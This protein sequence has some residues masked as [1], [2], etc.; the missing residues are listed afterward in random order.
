[1]SVEVVIQ[2]ADHLN[3]PHFG[4]IAQSVGSVFA[5]AL[6]Y[7]YPLRVVGPVFLISP[8]VSTQA[9]NTF[10][11]ARRLPA[12]LVTRTLSI[13]MDVMWM[14][15]KTTAAKDTDAFHATPTPS[16]SSPSGKTSSPARKGSFA[17]DSSTPTTTTNNSH[18][19]TIH[20][21]TALEE[22]E[23]L[24]SLE[25]QR[26][27]S[28]DFPPHRPLRH[29]VRPKH[30]SLYLAMNRQRM[31]EPCSQGQLGDVL[32][33]LEKYHGFGFSYSEVRTGV[34]AVWGDKDGLIS[35]K[36]IDI[37]ANTLNDLRLKILD[38]EGH[39]LVW[40]EGVM[41]WAIRGIAERR[42]ERVYH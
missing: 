11:W 17:L 36:G 26:E 19:P 21:L 37:L 15:S 9:A 5:L 14:F 6:A 32:V 29:V 16:Q 20:T 33:A 25:D 40:K 2:L 8:W 3:I 24:A 38:G 13:A 22:D 7:K 27:F 41:E 12:G 10:K 42:K 39:D 35:Q 30:V 4:L 18:D 34:S 1:M 31:E 28:T 23:L